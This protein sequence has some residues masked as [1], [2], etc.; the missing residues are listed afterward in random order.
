MILSFEFGICTSRLTPSDPIS[1]TGTPPPSLLDGVSHDISGPALLQSHCGSPNS[2]PPACHRY[3]LREGR[4]G[5][6][7]IHWLRQR[8]VRAARLVDR[9]HGTSTTGLI[10]STPFANT[11]QLILSY[12]YCAYDAAITSM[13]AHAELLGFSLASITGS[14][15]SSSGTGRQQE[16]RRS[17]DSAFPSHC[18]RPAT[19]VLLLT[20]PLSLRAAPHGPHSLFYI[21]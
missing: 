3:P 12:K 8:F 2:S 10:G 16:R 21:G 9:V 4:S 19:L 1:N 14:S 20:I 5:K 11:P 7:T 6:L 18:P 15:V 13:L 17:W